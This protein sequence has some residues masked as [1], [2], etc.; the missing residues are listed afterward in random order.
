MTSAHLSSGVGLA[1]MLVILSVFLCLTV[2]ARFVLTKKNRK[3]IVKL[4]RHSIKSSKPPTPPLYYPPDIP[5]KSD[6]YFYDS[7]DNIHDNKTW[8]PTDIQDIPYMDDSPR[9][10]NES[11]TCSK[12]SSIC[13]GFSTPTESERESSLVTDKIYDPT[14]SRLSTK[15]GWVTIGLS[16]YAADVGALVIA[17][18]PAM[19]GRFGFVG[20]IGFA[21]ASCFPHF[22]MLWLGQLVKESYHKTMAGE[23]SDETFIDWIGKKF[24]SLSLQ[25]FIGLVMVFFAFAQLT[26]GLKTL[27]VTMSSLT[28]VPVWQSILATVLFTCLMAGVGGIPSGILGMAFQGVACTILVVLGVGAT[29]TNFQVDSDRLATVSAGIWPDSLTAAFVWTA[30]MAGSDLLN[31]GDWNRV[32]AAKDKK[33]LTW[34]VIFSSLLMGLTML[35]FGIVGVFEAS[36]SD[37]TYVNKM[38]LSLSGMTKPVELYEEA[39]FVALRRQGT[40]WSACGV[41]IAV[42][43]CTTTVQSQQQG[44]MSVIEG[45]LKNLKFLGQDETA[46][47]FRMVSIGL[48]VFMSVLSGLIAAFGDLSVTQML[49]VG[50]LVAGC[51]VAPVFLGLSDKV[52]A[53]GMGVGCGVA[54]ITVAVFGWINQQTLLGGLEQ[55]LLVDGIEDWRTFLIFILVTLLGALATLAVSWLKASSQK[56]S[57]QQASPSCFTKSSELSTDLSTE[58][59][60]G[61]SNSSCAPKAK[62]DDD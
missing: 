23:S 56:P 3:N 39:F 25:I 4:F 62:F 5:Y 44:I 57:S 45:L 12:R 17:T 41:L 50:N 60:Y 22:L 35:G 26:S 40:A 2:L 47:K 53:L 19:G 51:V 28:G 48:I 7:N 27:A 36:R 55:F 14:V 33:A 15:F 37:T 20:L 9:S 58:S 10:S 11:R 13:G 52:T 46:N 8:A 31:L 30:A 6:P 18:A 24:L 38:D 42:A 21:F 49:S 29:A 59:G 43:V 61:C 1:M 16:F 34:G 54:L 32:W